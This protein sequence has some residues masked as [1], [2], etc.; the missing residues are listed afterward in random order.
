M[1][2]QMYPTIHM[3][4]YIK[5]MLSAFL[6]KDYW[7]RVWILQEVVLSANLSFR[8]RSMLLSP[9]DFYSLLCYYRSQVP[10]LDEPAQDSD[11]YGDL[12][13]KWW[14]SVFLAGSTS[15]ETV[16]NNELRCQSLPL[17]LLRLRDD[18][19]DNGESLQNALVPTILTYSA[20]EC[21]EPFDHF[22]GILGLTKSQLIPDYHM[23][24]L[25]LY[26]RILSEGLLEHCAVEHPQFDEQGC[27]EMALFCC[28]ILTPLELE[29]S[30]PVVAL[31]TSTILRV[32]NIQLHLG[33]DLLET[34][35]VDIKRGFGR[36]SSSSSSFLAARLKTAATVYRGIKN[37]MH[38][39]FK[40]PCPGLRTYTK[41]EWIK[42]AENI[43]EDVHDK[44][45]S[46]QDGQKL[47]EKSAGSP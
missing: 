28:K 38:H 41:D 13:G 35:I 23:N 19:R 25:E 45:Q 33:Y 42:I 12:T 36:E 8:F 2:L 40:P 26:L 34:I 46:S 7:S 47:D 14:L 21:T 18:L 4:W 27:A 43:F 44:F 24:R 31:T 17:Q 39:Y 16:S 6:Q 22:F 15:L 37:K 1:L 20:Q 32:C 3:S 5:A 9:D 10:T 29:I 11:P 30:H